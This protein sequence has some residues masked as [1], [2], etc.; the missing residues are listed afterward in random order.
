MKGNLVTQILTYMLIFGM[1]IFFVGVQLF[2]TDS[3]WHTQLYIFLYLPI[4]LLVFLE[5]NLFFNFFKEQSVKLFTV[6]LCY[7][8]LSSAWGSEGLSFG[9]IKKSLM[10]F[11]F[12]YAVYYLVLKVIDIWRI[13]MIAVGLAALISLYSIY[14]YGVETDFSFG[15]RFVGL[16]VLSNPLLSS[17]YFG[18]LCVFS[19]GLL[20]ASKKSFK[21]I[22]LFLC[23]VV[24]FL[25][26]F[27]TKSRTPLV[28]F[29]GVVL[30]LLVVNFYYKKKTALKTVFFILV[31]LLVA[32]IV[33]WEDIAVRGVSHRPEIW[34][35]AIKLI[36][37]KLWFGYGVGTEFEIYLKSI[38]QSFYDPH[39]IHLG[40]L[41]HFGVVGF[42]GWVLTLFLIAIKSYKQNNDI[43]IFIVLPLLVYGVL[44]GISEGGN[45]VSRPKEV[46]YISWVP[47][48]LAIAFISCSIQNKKAEKQSI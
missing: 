27:L 17:H 3:K 4:V 35:E 41:Y 40:V 45:I 2:P 6:L 13:I 47:I 22:I 18:F 14:S 24:F 11:L 5:S 15:G 25:C 12:A 39:N 37:D 7:F 43:L 9:E 38:K 42:I 19:L 16:G 30:T 34:G 26:A 8:A 1:L 29:F 20:L 48:S 28:G 33:A 44:G 31:T 23:V 32:V 36:L 21:K 46:W 10:V